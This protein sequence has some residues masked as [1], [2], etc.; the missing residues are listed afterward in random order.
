MYLG[1]V[2][3][4]VSKYIFSHDFTYSVKAEAFFFLY[5]FISTIYNWIASQ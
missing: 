3:R 4:D 1:Y 5:I 2:G